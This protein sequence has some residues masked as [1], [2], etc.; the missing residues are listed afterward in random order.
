MPDYANSKI[1]RIKSVSHPEIQYYGSTTQSLEQ[2]FK[3]HTYMRCTSRKVF[4]WDDAVIELIEDYPCDN[5]EVLHAREKVWIQNN[6]CVNH[7]SRGCN[8][9]A[10]KQKQKEWYK[11]HK[12]ELK[13][14]RDANRD[15]IN[16]RKRE[17]RQQKKLSIVDA[18]DTSETSDSRPST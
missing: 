8:Y 12:D 10:Y 13:E 5:K 17:L 2:R 4:E 1:Y 18:K 11:M 16:A 9:N 3:E 14:K 15:K 7:H 6:I